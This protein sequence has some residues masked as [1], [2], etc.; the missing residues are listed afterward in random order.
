[1]EA[2]N[3]HTPNLWTCYRYT[4]SVLIGFQS[5]LKKRIIMLTSPPVDETCQA[6]YACAALSGRTLTH[7]GY[8]E[9]LRPFGYQN[10]ADIP[11][12][13]NESNFV[14]CVTETIFEPKTQLYD[15][16]IKDGK[17]YSG[18][19]KASLLLRITSAD[20]ARYKRLIAAQ[21]KDLT[22]D[23]SLIKF[24]VELNNRILTALETARQRPTCR[25]TKEDILA[26][27]LEPKDDL[28]LLI[29]LGMLY[30]PEVEFEDMND[31]SCL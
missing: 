12:L 8:N 18:S 27:G 21:N 15:V 11:V 14:C 22:K 9:P 23:E 4:N 29:E 16:F 17:F 20:N 30:C 31:C 19:E 26:V 13:S 25:V 2:G 6:V 10:L 7:P 28:P 1:M 3:A 24:F 5:I